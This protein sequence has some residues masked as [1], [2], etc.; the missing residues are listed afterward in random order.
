MALDLIKYPTATF[1]STRCLFVLQ[2]LDL[3]PMGSVVVK[4]LV[5]TAR[6]HNIVVVFFFSCS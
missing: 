3:S 1:C 4:K 2:K 6:L 5:D